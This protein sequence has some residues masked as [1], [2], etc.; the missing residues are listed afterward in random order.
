M[1]DGSIKHSPVLHI[2][3]LAMTVTPTFFPELIETL[4]FTNT[5]FNCLFLLSHLI[6]TESRARV[7]INGIV[8]HLHCPIFSYT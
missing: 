8:S 5:P 7:E 4:S 3:G 6:N 1:S 2:K